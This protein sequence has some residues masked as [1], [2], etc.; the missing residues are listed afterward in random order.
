MRMQMV[1]NWPIFAKQFACN[2]R[3]RYSTLYPS[4]VLRLCAATDSSGSGEQ[5]LYED[6]TLKRIFEEPLLDEIHEQKEFLQA[7]SSE[8]KVETIIQDTRASSGFDPDRRL[9]HSNWSEVPY[10]EPSSLWPN[11]LI[12]S[13]RLQ[14]F[15]GMRTTGDQ[16]ATE[17]RLEQVQVAKN[18]ARLQGLWTHSS[19]H[20]VSWDELDSFYTKFVSYGEYRQSFL[21]QNRS[22]LLELAA[23]I[24]T[25]ETRS[26]RRTF[27]EKHDVKTEEMGPDHPQ[28]VPRSKVRRAIRQKWVSW[29][30]QYMLPFRRGSLAGYLKAYV[31]KKLLEREEN[32]R[33][34]GLGTVQSRDPRGD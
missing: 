11:H 12:H 32:E 13:H 31:S 34:L 21:D 4:R 27:L 16:S 26:S 2:E 22:K 3:R 5:T 7:I 8:D 1:R 18:A 17:R 24:A 25:N 6:E 30:R 9:R 28:L 15:Y 33:R 23:P 20:G 29:T 19:S 14:P 10:P